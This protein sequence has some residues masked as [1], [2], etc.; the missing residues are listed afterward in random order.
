MIHS[1][2]FNCIVI[3]RLLLHLSYYPQQ[4]MEE[5]RRMEAEMDPHELAKIK[6]AEAAA[7]AH[8]AEKSKHYSTLGSAFKKMPSK[9][10]GLLSSTSMRKK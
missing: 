3:N 4:E 7:A 10:G 6:E 1:F 5:K 8:D 9:G 2:Y